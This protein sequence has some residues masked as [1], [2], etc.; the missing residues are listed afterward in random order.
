MVGDRDTPDPMKSLTAQL[1]TM[2][3]DLKKRDTMIQELY[4]HLSTPNARDDAIVKELADTKAQL[5]KLQGR[6]EGLS[7]PERPKIL[8]GG[9]TVRAKEKV[10][11]WQEFLE[12]PVTLSQRRSR[13][14]TPRVSRYPLLFVINIES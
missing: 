2:Q 10:G 1:A 6:V 13:R 14:D 12:T 11:K 4:K 9:S 3:E 7:T 5:E 8:M